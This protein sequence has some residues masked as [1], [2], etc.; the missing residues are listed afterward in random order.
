MKRI[1]GLIMRAILFAALLFSLSSCEKDSTSYSIQIFHE[2]IPG[3]KYHGPNGT[4]WGYNQ[5]KI[6][7]KGANVFMYVIENENLDINQNPNAS[8]PSK[9]VLYGKYGEGAWTKGASL[10]T[11][12]PGNILIDSQGAVHLIVFEP[13]YTSPDE[14]GSYGRLVHYEFS[15][16]QQG[17]I[18]TYTRTIIQDNDGFKDGENVNIRIGAS[19]SEDDNIA[20]SYGL[21]RSMRVWHKKRGEAQWTME[22]AGSSLETDYYYPFTLSSSS[23]Y[24][25]LAVQDEWTGPSTP[26]KYQIIRFFEKR[27]SGQW[28]STIISDQRTHSLASTRSQLV[29]NCEIMEDNSGKIHLVYQTRLD[30]GDQWK[31]AF[32]HDIISSRIKTSNATSGPGNNGSWMRL[33]EAGGEIFYLC[34]A[35]DKLYIKKGAN[36]KYV[37]LDVPAV[38]GMYIYTSATRGGTGRGEAYLDILMLCGSSSAYPNAKNYYVRI[39]K[40]DLEKLE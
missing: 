23:G 34:S 38:D 2:A 24:Y 32:Y 6:V 9:I 19:I 26:V 33:V 30:P 3:S 16:A 39:L 21:F 10:N 1:A 5:S 11:S 4:W 22:Y 12:R 13:T 36:G 14:N 7:R 27:G 20:I 40:S 28:S 25:I 31:N 29:E 35:W 17:N 8:N 15:G 37:K 18:T